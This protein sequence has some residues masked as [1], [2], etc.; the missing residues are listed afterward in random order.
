MDNFGIGFVFGMMFGVA[1]TLTM[2]A[3]K[4]IILWY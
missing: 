4:G 2:L 3:F 1:V